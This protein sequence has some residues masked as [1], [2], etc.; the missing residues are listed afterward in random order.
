MHRL[1]LCLLN[2]AFLATTIA[3]PAQTFTTM[4]D[5]DGSNGGA[6]PW[7]WLVQGV[8]GSYYGEA[9]GIV[10]NNDRG[11]I[12]KITS[13]GAFTTVHHFDSNNFYEAAG[14]I[15]GMVRAR[16]GDL[17]GAG[18][19]GFYGSGTVFKVTPQDTVTTVYSFCAL[20]ANCPDGTFPW[21]PPI[22][23]TDGNFYGTT[24]TGGTTDCRNGCGTVYRVT[25]A[26]VLTTLYSFHGPDGANPH[27]RLL[28]ASDGNF[29]GTTFHGG[30][31]LGRCNNNYA[32]GCGT[33]FRI[34][35]D[36][37]FT[38]LHVFCL[39]SGCPDGANLPGG[40][41]QGSDGYLYGM[42]SSLVNGVSSL[43]RLSLQGELTTLY[44]FPAGWGALGE[45]L[46]APDGNFYGM[47]CCGGT[48][49][50]IF[51]MT[52]TG[53]VTTLHGFC[54][55]YPCPGGMN[56]SGSL[57]LGSDG[58]F[59]GTTSQGG[60]VNGY[61]TVFSFDVG[62]KPLTVTKAGS[63]T[64]VGGDGHIYCGSAC[65][66]VYTNGKQLQLSAIPAAG[67][68]FSGWTGCDQVQGSY[69]VVTMNG[70]RNVAA[71]FTSSA[72]TLTSLILKPSTVQGGQL[73]A[74]TI[75]LSGPAPEGGLGVSVA[76]NVPAAAHPPSWIVVPGGK[77]TASFS[78][79]T[80]PVKSNTVVTISASIGTS[81]R[82]ATLTITTRQGLQESGL[83]VA[84]WKQVLTPTVQP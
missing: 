82:L 34:T 55:Q 70:A 44:K 17:Y 73:S 22:E 52:P 69:C 12:F 18:G 84:S 9:Q 1:V 77:T 47:V 27:A 4:Y 53:T 62:F 20:G 37:V 75:T 30:S 56:P 67:F 51:M 58:L 60:D 76:A 57:A 41:V 49:G 72:V 13:S 50:S 38:T 21:A 28:L 43:F 64:V 35:P 80:F 15:G 31:T 81:Q 42:T 46:Q 3:S 65:S 83:S 11:A 8:D 32:P 36:G 6:Y 5:F 78:V 10:E 61:G 40:L 33:V 66:S 71:G 7:A 2:C 23:G 25:P 79:Q 14:P 54:Q 19:G 24:G 63:G 48:P 68:T 45:L 26:G 29:Y 16:N 39:Q 59:Y 74:G